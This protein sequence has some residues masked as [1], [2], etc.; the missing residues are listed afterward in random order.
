MI[1]EYFPVAEAKGID[2]GLDETASPM[3]PAVAENL[4]LILKNALEN[5]LKYTPQGGVVTLKLYSNDENAVFEIIDNGPGI[6]LS[7]RQRVFDPFYRLSETTSEGSG[8]G[9]AIAMEA[10]LCQG[11]SLSLHN[12]QEGPGLILRYCQRTTLT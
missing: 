1:A 9:L 4:Y 2:L 5:S 10:A 3:L 7:E 12:R 8:L 6:P 11:G